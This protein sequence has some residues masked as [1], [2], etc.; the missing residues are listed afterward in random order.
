MTNGEKNLVIPK[1]NAFSFE[2]VMICA[3]VHLLR[4][5]AEE[6]R[7]RARRAKQPD[8]RQAADLMNREFTRMLAE[9]ENPVAKPSMN[10]NRLVKLQDPRK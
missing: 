1:E 7:L 3:L 2:N 10:L 8:E 5:L 6:V 9:L 4:D